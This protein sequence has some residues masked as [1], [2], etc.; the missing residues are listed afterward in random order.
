MHEVAELEALPRGR[1]V[2]VPMRL[3]MC[4]VAMTVHDRHG[5][6]KRKR[7]AERV[8][9][10]HVHARA[11]AR[12][13][14][15]VRL[16]V[17]PM[18][19]L[20]LLLLE[21]VLVLVL[22]LVIVVQPQRTRRI[23]AD[24]DAHRA[25]EARRKRLRRRVRVHTLVLKLLLR[26]LLVL[27]VLLLIL[28]RMRAVQQLCPRD[29]VLRVGQRA[30]LRRGR[31]LTLTL[32]LALALLRMHLHSTEPMRRPRTR[33]TQ[34]RRPTR[35]AARLA[36]LEILL[37]MRVCVRRASASASAIHIL[38]LHS[39]TLTLTLELLAMLLLL[40]MRHVVR[41]V[42]VL[43]LLRR[44]VLLRR[45]H[46]RFRD[47]HRD[48][49]KR[50]RLRKGWDLLVRRDVLQR[51]DAHVY[52]RCV[53]CTP[54]ARTAIICAGAV[55]GPGE[56][57]HDGREVEAPARA[58][59]R[60]RG[61]GALAVVAGGVIVIIIIVVVIGGGG[62]SSGGGGGS[63]IGVAGAEAEGRV[64]QV[65]V[66]LRKR[67]GLRTRPIRLGQRGT[68]EP[69]RLRRERVREAVHTVSCC[70]RRTYRTVVGSGRRGEGVRE[71]DVR[72]RRRQR[73]GSRRGEA[74][75]VVVVRVRADTEVGE[76]AR[77]ELVLQHGL[78]RARA[79]P[80]L[81][82]LVLA[83]RARAHTEG[84]PDPAVHGHAHAHTSVH[85]HVAAH[86]SVRIHPPARTHAHAH[87]ETHVHLVV[88]RH[89]PEHAHALLRRELLLLGLLLAEGVC[90]ARRARTRERR[91]CLVLRASG[92]GGVEW[93]L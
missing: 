17:L 75:C 13:R 91:C 71:P 70:T 22:V 32:S 90:E 56:V 72:A 25:A 84:H 18:L 53:P 85:V 54:R 33:R 65:R 44:S 64:E 61:R 39:L 40:A 31:F 23:R 55:A 51:A 30:H 10:E 26:V 63:T 20:L 46:L 79:A 58:C 4:V 2:C 78:R 3:S 82:E 76:G 8:V 87:A 9:V 38:Q 6:G 77:G 73:R 7:Q 66:D 34:V 21:L 92:G 12:R 57:H 67:L 59:T 80:E 24:A 60:W 41:R 43:L 69:D 42:V 68:L 81:A 93:T 37:R 27:L 1:G 49:P 19:L 74:E 89:V 5:Q 28:L 52:V 45:V 11:H 29:R 35:D 48:F 83:R 14:A 50:H 16:Q 36:V 47:R 86:A 15:H 88:Q 62:V